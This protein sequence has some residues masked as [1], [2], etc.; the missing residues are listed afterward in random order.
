MHAMTRPYQNGNEMARPGLNSN[1]MVRQGLN[2]NNMAR[3]SMAR[4][5]IA[6]HGLALQSKTCI[7]DLIALKL[8][9]PECSMTQ[10]HCQTVKWIAATITLYKTFNMTQSGCRITLA[11]QSQLKVS[12]APCCPAYSPGSIR[13]CQSARRDSLPFCLLSV[14]ILSE[15][16]T[17]LRGRPQLFLRTF[18]F[19]GCSAVATLQ[20]AGSG[21]WCWSARSPLAA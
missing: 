15:L 14:R 13:V 6:W 7:K 11:A 18:G 4:L 9:Q 3:R 19:S 16:Q 5:S 17:P 8:L 21:A 10:L 2:G 12:S 20:K 1:E